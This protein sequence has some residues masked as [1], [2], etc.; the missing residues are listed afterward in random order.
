MNFFR[1]SKVKGEL[2]GIIYRIESN[3]ANNYKDAAQE[4]F[5][6]FEVKFTEMVEDDTLS[7]KQRIKYEMK[8]SGYRTKL[9]GFTHKDQK[10][11][12]T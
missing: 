8:L 11:T 3:M 6:E 10:A 4:A 12:W 2:D 9:Q 5:K 7:D 1:W